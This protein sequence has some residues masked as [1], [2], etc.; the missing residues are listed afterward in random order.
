M[1]TSNRLVNSLPTR[2]DKIT[3]PKNTTGSNE[4]AYWLL[5]TKIKTR[6]TKNYWTTDPPS[7]TGR[8]RLCD[9]I[10]GSLATVRYCNKG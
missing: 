5:G 7:L 4:R 3:L 2:Y 9:V 6:Y 8:Q 10:K 1:L